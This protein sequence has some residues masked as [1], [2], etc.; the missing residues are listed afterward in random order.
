MLSV[1]AC[2]CAASTAEKER[3]QRVCICVKEKGK[4]SGTLPRLPAVL[5]SSW[6]TPPSPLC[7]AH[8]GQ[9][10]TD[11]GRRQQPILLEERPVGGGHDLQYTTVV[12]GDEQEEQECNFPD[13]CCFSAFSHAC[14]SVSSNKS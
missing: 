10:Y 8:S 5:L 12:E 7:F 6:L 14:R 1:C 2:L 4:E 11:V 13:H 9:W 3:E